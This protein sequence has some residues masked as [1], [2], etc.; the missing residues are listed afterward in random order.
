MNCANSSSADRRGGAPGPDDVVLVARIRDRSQDGY[1]RHGNHQLDQRETGRRP[2]RRR[3]AG[4]RSLSSSSVQQKLTPR[5]PA[6]FEAVLRVPTFL[7]TPSSRFTCT[8][9]PMMTGAFGLRPKP[10]PDAG[11]SHAVDLDHVELIELAIAIGV[12]EVR[13]RP[14]AGE[15]I[16]RH[17]VAPAARAA[18]VTSVRNARR[19]D[20]QCRVRSDWGP[21]FARLPCL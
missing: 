21:P 10:T 16:Q 4:W 6:S 9:S 11:D 20:Q 12:E 1:D 15:R 8:S 13:R 5:D 18:D 14:R 19:A 7:L 3:N 2:A 17:D